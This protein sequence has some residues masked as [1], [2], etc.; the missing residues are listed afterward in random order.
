[1]SIGIVLGSFL[2]DPDTGTNLSLNLASEAL[3]TVAGVLFIQRYLD[4]ANQKEAEK[5][6]RMI[7]DN[8]RKLNKLLL[9]K[10]NGNAQKSFKKQR[11]SSLSYGGKKRIRSNKKRRNHQ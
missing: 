2:L 3:G 6:K 7:S 11:Y 1:V 9:E 10:E 8:F 5:T 4:I